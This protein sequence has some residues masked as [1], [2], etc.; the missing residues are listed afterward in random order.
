MKQV[1]VHPA[2]YL[3]LWHGI[4][5]RREIPH[6]PTGIWP[7]KEWATPYWLVGIPA[8]LEVDK[9]EPTVCKV[10]IKCRVDEATAFLKYIDFQSAFEWSQSGCEDFQI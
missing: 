9:K 1:F 2:H 6:Q 4:V 8:I 5:V 7:A 3:G 10:A